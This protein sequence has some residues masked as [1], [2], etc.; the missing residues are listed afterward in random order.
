MGAESSA[1]ANE[2]SRSGGA[3][4]ASAS[5][6]AGAGGESAAAGAAGA[7]D[8]SPTGALSAAGDAGAG[9]VSRRAGSARALAAGGIGAGR[10]GVELFGLCRNTFALGRAEARGCLRLELGEA[11]DEAFAGGAQRGEEAVELGFQRVELGEHAV[12]GFLHAGDVAGGLGAGGGAQLGGAAFGGLEDQADLLGG[13]LRHGRSG[14]VDVGVELVGDA[15]EVLVHRR[16][17]VAAAPGGE[18]ATFD[19]IPIHDRSG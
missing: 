7:G 16:R 9:G 3:G 6:D 12:G 8:A 10:A 13:A 15:T 2:D 17:V 4:V 11:L 1:A 14:R 19:P 18:V 5:G